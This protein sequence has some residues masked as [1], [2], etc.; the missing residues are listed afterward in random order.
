MPAALMLALALTQVQCREVIEFPN[1]KYPMYGEW[2]P[3]E[4]AVANSDAVEEPG[5][6]VWTQERHRVKGSWSKPTQHTGP[7]MIPVPNVRYMK[8]TRERTA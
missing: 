8:G 3:C 6:V 4:Q 5:A 2:L 7:E 1:S